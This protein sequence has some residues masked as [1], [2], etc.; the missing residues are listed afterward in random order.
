MQ[1]YSIDPVDLIIGKRD[2]SQMLLVRRLANNNGKWL[3]SWAVGQSIRVNP[4][5]STP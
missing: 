2:F 5:I 3:F 1:A 4:A